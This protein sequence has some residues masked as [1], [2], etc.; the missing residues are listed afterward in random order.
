MK[1]PS[2]YSKQSLKRLSEYPD[3]LTVEE[4]SEILSVCTKTVYKMIKKG[5]LKKQNVGRLFRI[6]KSYI[7]AY[8]GIENKK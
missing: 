8:L 3:V 7:I 5:D 1:R 4:A 2:L 6:P